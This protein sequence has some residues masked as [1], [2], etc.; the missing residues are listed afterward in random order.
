[1]P[2]AAYLETPLFESRSR[3]SLAFAATFLLA[4]AASAQ[5]TRTVVEPV[6]PP[7]C[8]TL[9]AQLSS[10]AGSFSDADEAKLDTAR[11]QKALDG[12]KPRQAVELA[13]GGS[14]NAFLTGPIELRAGVTLLVDKGVTLYASRDPKTYEMSP[15]SC[16]IVTKEGGHSCKPLISAR[17][18]KGA[19]IMG[20]GI[21]DERGGAKIIGQDKSWWDLAND[22]RDNR[23]QQ[24]P[25][26][27]DIN[28]SDDFTIYKITLKN[29]AMFHVVYAHG[30][31]F[32]V[33]GLKIDTPKNARNTDGVD[34][35]AAK[36]ITVTHSFIR[37]G[38]DNI[39]IKGGDGAV[40]NMTVI[41]NH[42]YYGHGMSIGSETSA[43]VNHILVED[44][45]LDGTESGIRIKS[46]P[47]RG[48]LV[49]DVLYNDICIRN[50][51]HPIQLETAYNNPGS[52]VD[53]FPVF[54]KILLQDVRISSSK[55]ISLNGYDHTHRVGIQFNGVL[56][57]NPTSYKFIAQHA[58]VTYGP[59]PV[60]F[61]VP[62][63]DTTAR[64]KMA[65]G[66]PAPCTDKFVTFPVTQ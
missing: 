57:D 45:S 17:S 10:P 51:N 35:S 61:Q 58:D 49:E 56:L 32:T 26:L 21:I 25:R 12:C 44:M 9:T 54:Q 66:S 13:V 47:T 33:W 23:H 8:T 50:S 29:S 41:H 42:F 24:V 36:N 38:D 48:G 30:D 59:Q 19:G 55:T 34:P 37:T 62:G 31:G 4:G 65:N 43:G 6:I 14:N 52:K 27:I 5:D 46:N 3:I 53:A 40:T 1:M 11:I 16:G 64:G 20:D 15:G 22:A 63:E 28:K 7:V 18:A 60:N 39:A 2:C